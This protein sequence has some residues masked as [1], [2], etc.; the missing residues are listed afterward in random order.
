MIHRPATRCYNPFNCRD[1]RK[2]TLPDINMHSSHERHIRFMNL[3]DPLHAWDCIYAFSA[4]PTLTWR[5][6]CCS[7]PSFTPHLDA[8]CCGRSILS[9]QCSL[10]AALDSHS[11]A[12][13]ARTSEQLVLFAQRSM[14][15][16][17]IEQRALENKDQGAASPHCLAL[18]APKMCLSVGSASHR[19]WARYLALP[20]PIRKKLGTQLIATCMLP[21]RSNSS[22]LGQ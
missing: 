19:S 14:W 1:A 9:M 6:A 16:A 17:G 21:P 15:I 2:N 12:P 7:H 20:F 11:S 10:L 5:W 8:G 3:S 22:W 18:P 13:C 4:R